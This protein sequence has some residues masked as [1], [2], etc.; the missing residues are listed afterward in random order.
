MRLCCIS[1]THSLHDQV[2]LP[3]ASPADVLVHAGDFTGNGTIEQVSDFALWMAMSWLGR[4][5]VGGRQS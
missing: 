1:D 2:V 4:K 3:Q 5:I